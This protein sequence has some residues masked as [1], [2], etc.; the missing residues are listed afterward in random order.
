MAISVAE[1]EQRTIRMT[2]PEWM[3]YTIGL[4]GIT[5]ELLG[6]ELEDVVLRHPKSFPWYEPGAI[7]WE[8]MTY[9]PIEDPDYGDFTDSWGCVWRTAQKGHHGVIVTHPLADPSA[10]DT[11]TP[12]DPD[13]STHFRPIDWEEQR[14]RIRREGADG[15][16]PGGGL[17]HGYHLLRLEY[18]RGFE[19]LMCDLADDTPEI[20]RIVD[21]VHA[22]NKGLVS[23]FLDIG[24]RMISL[25]EDLGGQD[26]SLIGPKLF[27]KWVLPYQQELHGMAHERGALTS[28][29]CDGNI[30][31]VADQILAI[32]P[33]VFNPQDRANG[34]EAL[35]E[36]FKGRLCIALDFDRQH[37][38]PFGTPTE[39]EE[40]IE[41][42]VRTLGSRNGGL[43]IQCEVRGPIPPEN[44]EALASALEKYS[45]YWFA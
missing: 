22:F 45:T 34:V 31:D 19:N 25:P 17:D 14:Q 11:Y 8:H 9:G 39:I 21:M 26:G 40:L 24:A 6:K 13:R 7:D 3:P 33:D 29:H 36:A 41:Y 18:L 44:I 42:E 28:F 20:R 43:K 1:N 15:G 38:I 16:L 32:G 35:A 4:C 5:W 2:D 30:M 23:R 10:L 27:R 12:P 37:T